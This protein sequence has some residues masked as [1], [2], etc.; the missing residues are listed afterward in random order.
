MDI[1]QPDLTY[2]IGT[3]ALEI[4]DGFLSDQSPCS[5]TYSLIEEGQTSYDTTLFTFD[6]TSPIITINTADISL[7]LLEKTLILKAVSDDS[8]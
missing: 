4:P 6:S 5:I 2:Y 7:N 8:G 1:P 3:G